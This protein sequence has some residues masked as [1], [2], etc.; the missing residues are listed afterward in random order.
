MFDLAGDTILFPHL[1]HQNHC[2][3][4][5]KSLKDLGFIWAEPL[6]EQCLYGIF[7]TTWGVSSPN[8]VLGAQVALLQPSPFLLQMIPVSHKSGIFIPIRP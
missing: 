7:G 6:L 4:M 1:H 8:I 2:A 5:E 3:Q